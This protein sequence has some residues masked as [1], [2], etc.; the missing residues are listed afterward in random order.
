MTIHWNTEYNGDGTMHVTVADSETNLRESIDTNSSGTWDR[1]TGHW[2]DQNN[3][4][5]PDLPSGFEDFE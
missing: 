3:N 4:S 5:H 2:T 1:S